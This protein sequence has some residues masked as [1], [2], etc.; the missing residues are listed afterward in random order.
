MSARDWSRALVFSLLLHLLLALAVWALAR[1][2]PARPPAV[3]KLRLRAAVPA[4]PKPRAPVGQRPHRPKARKETRRPPRRTAPRK[5]AAKKA[6]KNQDLWQALDE[7]VQRHDIDWRWVRGHSGVPGN[8][9]A[10]ELANR[11]IDER[12]K[13]AE[14]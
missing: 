10:D 13:R 11:A 6:V 12:V 5:T 7:E 9:K 3:V 2:E 14:A 8:E 4:A 1:P